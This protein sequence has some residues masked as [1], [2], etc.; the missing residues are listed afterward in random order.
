MTD[1]TLP[2]NEQ[3]T[4]ENPTAWK[5]TACIL[6]ECNCGILVQTSPAEEGRHLKKI[7]GDKNHPASAGYTC[8]KALRLEHYQ[9]A[10]GRLTSPLR[11]RDDGSYEEIDWDTAITEIADGFARIAQTYGGDK[12]FYYGG[13]GQG[14]HLGGAYSSAFL[15][16][17]GSRYRSNAL[18]AP[19]KLVTGR[20]PHPA[21][22]D[23]DGIVG[24]GHV[25]DRKRASNCSTRP[26]GWTSARPA[27]TWSKDR[28][29]PARNMT[30]RTW[31]ST[32]RR[33][34]PATL[35]T[36]CR[37]ITAPSTSPTPASCC[38][39]DPSSPSSTA[40]SGSAE[41]FTRARR[42]WDGSRLATVCASPPTMVSTKPAAW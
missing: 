32:A 2:T 19:G 16:P 38:R 36:T 12:I 24:G 23:N 7:R 41:K 33:L 4:N 8:N 5:P 15:K 6:C 14:N 39:S 3:P 28:C 17:L 18:A 21:D 11:R 22:A 9:N 34:T 10:Q 29:V 31:C 37:P 30:C 42:F 13:G 20:A 27:A 40:L 35:P 26:A 1:R 25:V